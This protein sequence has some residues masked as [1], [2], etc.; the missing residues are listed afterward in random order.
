LEEGAVDDTGSTNELPANGDTTGCTR[1]GNG[2]GHP[3]CTCCLAKA[4]GFPYCET[5]D[6][7][8]SP[9]TCG[10]AEAAQIKLATDIRKAS[11][12]TPFKLGL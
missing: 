6:F 1:C 4:D 8:K 7:G 11:L 12:D 3:A 5:C 9:C 2:W 10:A